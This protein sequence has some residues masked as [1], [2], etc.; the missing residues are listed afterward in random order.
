MSVN[1]SAVVNGTQ[2]VASCFDYEVL[3]IAYIAAFFPVFLVSLVG[4]IFIGI[5]VYKTK[6]LKKP[7]D[8]FTV[9]MAI[10]DLVYPI[11]M[12]PRNVASLFTSSSW[13]TSGPLGQA[14]CKLGSFSIEVFTL[15]SVSGSCSYRSPSIWSC[16]FSPP[17]PTDQLKPVPLLGSL[18][19][20]PWSS[21]MRSIK[22]YLL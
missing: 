12:L 7:V 2:T 4:N 16:S 17:F 10:L 1:E 6:S 22:A 20:L 15:V 9:N 5:I 18:G 19:S 8:F 11:S 13:L 14:L 3:R 21:G